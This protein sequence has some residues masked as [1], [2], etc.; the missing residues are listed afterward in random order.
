MKKILVVAAL[1]A[2]CDAGD[3][4]VHRSPEQL[5][6]IADDSVRA[7]AAGTPPALA[8]PD[9]AGVAGARPLRLGAVAGAGVEAEAIVAPQGDRTQV[10]VQFGLAP[11]NASLRA[12]VHEGGCTQGATPLGESETM[13]YRGGGPAVTRLELPVAPATVFDGAHSVHVYDVRQ[14]APVLL[15]CAPIPRQQV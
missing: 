12:S 4:E 7:V 13:V 6:R 15:A 5:S 2:A 3:R 1:L 10:V 9:T 8:T 11:A 14:G